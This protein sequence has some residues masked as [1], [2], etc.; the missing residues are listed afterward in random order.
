MFDLFVLW[1]GVIVRAFRTHRSL[2]LDN[3]ALRPA[4]TTHCVETQTSEAK[5]RAV[6]D[7]ETQVGSGRGVLGLVANAALMR[8]PAGAMAEAGKATRRHLGTVIAA[9]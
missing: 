8:P 3:L 5:A 2:M 7:Q 9:L 4:A 6:G 1:C